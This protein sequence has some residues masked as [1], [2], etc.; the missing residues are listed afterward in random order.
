MGGVACG[1]IDL[2]AL[3][4]EDIVYTNSNLWMAAEVEETFKLWGNYGF[5]IVNFPNAIE[6]TLCDPGNTVANARIAM[7]LGLKLPAAGGGEPAS[8]QCHILW[9][10]SRTGHG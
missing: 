3:P 5:V 4:S 8:P 9:W 2:A 10:P 1:K 7:T 6:A